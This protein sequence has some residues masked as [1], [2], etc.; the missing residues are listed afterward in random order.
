MIWIEMPLP[1]HASRECDRWIETKIMKKMRRQDKEMETAKA[2][3]LLSAGEY[4]ILSTT[5]ADGQ[6]YGVPLNYVYHDDAIYFHCALNGHKIENIKNNPRVS[7][8]VV[9]HSKVIP[10]RFTTEYES[11][12]VFGVASEIQGPERYDALLWLVEK[13]SPAFIA[14]GKAYIEK[15]DKV[16]QV[17]KIDIERISGKLSPATSKG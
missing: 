9:G 1:S 3:Q 12:L 10:A 13:Y 15:H 16:T 8:A 11:V 17:I 5:A 6:P 2:V 14:E 7:F 4:G